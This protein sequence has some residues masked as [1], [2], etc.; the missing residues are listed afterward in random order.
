M[1]GSGN[2]TKDDYSD[3]LTFQWDVMDDAS[4]CEENQGE[5]VPGDV[6]DDDGATLESDMAELGEDT[7]FDPYD[8]MSR[9][10]P[11]KVRRRA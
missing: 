10:E 9:F 11:A 6:T 7:G 1:A 3:D 4:G 8:T 2:S 5:N